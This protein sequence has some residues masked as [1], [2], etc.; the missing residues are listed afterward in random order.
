MTHITRVFNPSTRSLTGVERKYAGQV[1]DSI[2]TIL[3]FE[4]T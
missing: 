1:G 3:H 2:S 4:Y